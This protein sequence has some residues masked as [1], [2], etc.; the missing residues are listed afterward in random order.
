MR[1]RT[2]TGLGTAFYIGDSTWVTAAH[3]VAGETSVRLTNDAIDIHATVA[4]TYPEYDLAVLVGAANVSAISWGETPGSGAEALVIG[5]GRGQR[6]LV[7]GVTRG[8]VSE[9]FVENGE[10]YIRTDAPANPGNS[11]GPLLNV[12]G[13]VIGIVQEKLVGASIEGV[14]YA[15]SADSVRA[16][17]R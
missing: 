10:T 6:T 16:L 13:E 15:L 4:K 8:I 17:L 9:R 14:T 7:A 1:I 3:V 11:G 12:C 5:Y 2:L